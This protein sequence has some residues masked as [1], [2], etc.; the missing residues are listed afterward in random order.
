MVQFYKNF[1][2][3][4]WVGDRVSIRLQHRLTPAAVEQLNREFRDLLCSRDIVQMGALPE[5][6]NEPEI[7]DLPRIVLA[8]FR[9]KFGRLRQFIDALNVAEIVP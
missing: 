5:E 3:Y 7:A 2:S 6:S 9:R 4:R 8:P 1:R